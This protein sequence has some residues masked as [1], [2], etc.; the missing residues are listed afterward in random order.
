MP[1]EFSLVLVAILAPELDCLMAIGPL[2]VAALLP[3]LHVGLVAAA[4]AAGD[5]LNMLTPPVRVVHLGGNRC[6]I[7]TPT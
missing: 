2:V 3:V 7:Q 1:K 5:V 4:V 6:R